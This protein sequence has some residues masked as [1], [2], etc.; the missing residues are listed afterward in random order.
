MKGVKNESKMLV[1]VREVR[2]SE[3]ARLI[4]ESYIGRCNKDL[5]PLMHIMA[6]VSDAKEILHLS[7]PITAA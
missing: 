3:V 7:H 5:L 2:P 1:N 6:D 4:F